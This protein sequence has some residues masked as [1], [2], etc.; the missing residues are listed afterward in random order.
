MEEE[1]TAVA[2]PPAEYANIDPPPGWEQWSKAKRGTFK[3]RQQDTQRKNEVGRGGQGPSQPQHHHQCQR[4]RGGGGRQEV[5]LF[6]GNRHL[7][8]SFLCGSRRPTSS[9]LLPPGPPPFISSFIPACLFGVGLKG[10]GWTRTENDISTRTT[11]SWA[12]RERGHMAAVLTC[13]PRDTLAK[14]RN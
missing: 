12:T 8:C 9:N 11:Q 3:Q 5:G 7:L 4:P 13:L 1:A 14:L 6:F 2:A 10:A